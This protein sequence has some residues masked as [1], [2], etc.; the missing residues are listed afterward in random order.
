MHRD[1][2]AQDQQYGLAR[3]VAGFAWPW[4]S[5]S[6]RAAFDIEIDGYGLRWNTVAK[7]WINSRHAVD[8]VGSIHTVQGYDLN[9]AGVII[10]PDLTFDYSSQRVS[11]V[12]SNYYDKKGREN[13]PRLGI[14]YDDEDLL[15]YVTNIYK[16]LLTRAIKGTY[17]YVADPSL[18]RYL[19][20]YV[21]LQEKTSGTVDI[22]FT[23]A[24][25]LVYRAAGSDES[26]PLR[27]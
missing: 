17:L 7:D 10:G 15:K 25:G 16:V 22:G 14:T 4:K 9:Y 27:H 21:P 24:P 12:R 2:R 23:R 11:F 3:L 13:N 5:K 8:E 6:D 19:Q 26:L 20:R 1:I 18:R